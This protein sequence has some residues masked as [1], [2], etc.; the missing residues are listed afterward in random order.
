MRKKIR[1]GTRKMSNLL[2]IRYRRAQ[3]GKIN[4]AV[5][6]RLEVLVDVLVLVL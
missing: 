2:Y 4:K 5:L 3:C 1:K 6:E